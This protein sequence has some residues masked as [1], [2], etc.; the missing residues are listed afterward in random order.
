MRLASPSF[1]YSKIQLFKH[2]AEV[3]L[4][5]T[6]PSGCI[7]IDLKRKV[8]SLQLY[9]EDYK[10]ASLFYE[11]VESIP[12]DCMEDFELQFQLLV[13]LDHLI[14]NTDRTDD[15]WLI[16]VTKDEKGDS[17]AP[18]TEHAI[19]RMK[20]NVKIAAIDNGLSLPFKFPNDGEFPFLWLKWPQSKVPF[21]TKT[22]QLIRP[23]LEDDDFVRSLCEALYFLH[24]VSVILILL[25]FTS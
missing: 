13:V 2:K 19:I 25:D 7:R 4:A 21:S 3:K 8:G 24:C 15:N 17:S 16:K 5:K 22:V 18:Q 1:N 23:K 6:V 9:V 10:A 12:D 20:H 14:R 11:N